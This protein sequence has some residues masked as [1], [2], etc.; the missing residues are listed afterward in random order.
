MET[1]RHSGAISP[2]GILL[3]VTVGVISAVVLGVVYSL[4]NVN[5]PY[6]K[7]HCLLTI[8]FGCLMGLAVG[9][10]AKAGKIR[11]NFVAAAYG[12]VIGLIGLYVAWGTD[13]LIRDI[14]PAGG[15]ISDAVIAFSPE[16]L[17]EY[18][19]W[20]YENGKWAVSGHKP[21]VGIQLGVVW[22]IEAITI[23]AGSTIFACIF[24]MDLP[25]CESCNRWTTKKAG[26]RKL[27]LVG[28]GEA[29]NR[30]LTG[31]LTALA[32]FNLAQDE[33]AEYLQLDMATCPACSESNYLT[34]KQN[35]QTLDSE[36]KPKT[37]SKSLL[38]NML[39]AGED[40]PLIENAGREPVPLEDGESKPEGETQPEI[41]EV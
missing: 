12:F 14:I 1:Y 25:F 39:V 29:L 36:G 30:L 4:G 32:E 7:I 19:K 11:N 38:E 21:W 5:I 2:V 17:W 26:E 33:E 6:V 13:F 3:A 9:L 37:D 23:L 41:G 24:I 20:F 22:S 8:G 27:S 15:Q 10:A 16:A 31:D 35:K 40:L 28:A 18:I 34:V